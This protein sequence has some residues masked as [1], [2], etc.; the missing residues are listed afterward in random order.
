MT[1]HH[2]VQKKTVFYMD[3]K[4]QLESAGATY[5]KGEPPKGYKEPHKDRNVCTY[6]MDNASLEWAIK[7]YLPKIK[8]PYGFIKGLI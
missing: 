7:H 5:Y 8:E 3:L 1:S 4:N 2:I 6:A